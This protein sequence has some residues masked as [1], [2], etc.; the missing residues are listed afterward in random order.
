MFDEIESTI[1][2]E[3]LKAFHLNDKKGKCGDKLD[4]HESLGKGC[5]KFPVMQY[6]AT[7][8]PNLPMVLETPNEYVLTTF[9]KSI[10]QQCLVCFNIL[11]LYSK[12]NQ[13]SR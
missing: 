11:L 10:V 12:E 5:I 13:F 9:Y 2:L 6:I 8:F 4:R 1:G 7:K 3:Y